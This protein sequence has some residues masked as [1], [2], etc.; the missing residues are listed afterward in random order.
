MIIKSSNNNKMTVLNLDSA[1]DVS[2]KNMKLLDTLVSKQNTVVLNHASWCGHCQVFKPE[3]EV[4]KNN[5]CNKVNVVQ[6]ENSALT[7][8]QQNKRLYKKIVPKDGAVYFPMIVVFIKKGSKPTTEKKIYDG[9]R[10]AMD[11]KTYIDTK[12]KP[13]KTTKGTKLPRKQRSAPM[14]GGAR[15]MA[16][17]MSHD[18]ALSLVE[19]N[20][21]LDAI[22]A[23]INSGIGM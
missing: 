6:I 1:E 12:I 21:E 10:T 3:W 11:L 9:N 16:S 2:A 14:A 15:E 13:A 23:K 5:V 19:L 4:F 22:I 17:P 20:R 18:Q 8:I 7:Q